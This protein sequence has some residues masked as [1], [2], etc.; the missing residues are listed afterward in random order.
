MNFWDLDAFKTES[1]ITMDQFGNGSIFLE[2]ILLKKRHLTIYF[3]YVFLNNKAKKM[4][5]SGI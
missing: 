3:Q 1:G 5:N 2:R 4:K